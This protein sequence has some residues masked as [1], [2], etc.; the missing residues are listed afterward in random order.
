VVA[1][2][3]QGD[4]G[5][6]RQSLFIV[7]ESGRQPPNSLSGKDEMICRGEEFD[8]PG[9]TPD[10]DTIYCSAKD[11][12]WSFSR[13]GHGRQIVPRLSQRLV[14]PVQRP[15][16]S[17]FWKSDESSF[18]S[19]VKGDTNQ[20]LA[21]VNVYSGEAEMLTDLP[22]TLAEEFHGMD[23]AQ[24]GSAAYFAVRGADEL[25]SLIRVTR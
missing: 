14:G 25:I 20:H 19:V 7:S 1:R 15:T 17:T 9:W 4:A 10:G 6:G 2:L 23:V 16:T 12:V 21:Q 24:D 3:R 22:G 11:S 8:V 18:L 5:Q 13:H